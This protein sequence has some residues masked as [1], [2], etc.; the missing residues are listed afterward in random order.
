MSDC[1]EYGATAEHEHHVI[2]RSLGGTRTVPVC[3]ACHSKVHSVSLTDVR[4]LT[5][6]AL[7]AKRARGEVSGTVPLGYR[8]E[9]GRLVP[10]PGEQAA[11]ARIRELRSEGVSYERIARQ[12]IVDGHQPRVG[13]RWHPTQIARV[14]TRETQPWAVVSSCS[15]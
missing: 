11:V 8:D 9:D 3:G 12:L 7:A 5:A 2:P 14:L 6:V 10:D 13:R 4:R 1:F 15:Q